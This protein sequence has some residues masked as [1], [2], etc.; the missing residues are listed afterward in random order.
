MQG[1]KLSLEPANMKVKRS[2]AQRTMKTKSGS[3]WC[4][5]RSGNLWKGRVLRIKSDNLLKYTC[6]L[7]TPANYTGKELHVYCLRKVRKN[8]QIGLRAWQVLNAVHYSS[9]RHLMCIY[10]PVCQALCWR[11]QARSGIPQA[12]SQGNVPRSTDFN[13]ECNMGL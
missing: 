5:W 13:T 6:K 1:A 10:P 2:W 12:S 11:L 3:V 4:G 7:H 9:T 8:R